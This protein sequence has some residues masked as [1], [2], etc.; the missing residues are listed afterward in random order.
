VRGGPNGEYEAR[1]EAGDESSG[2]DQRGEKG[3]GVKGGRWRRGA[4][5]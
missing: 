3:K 5:R 1:G 2:Q 4:L